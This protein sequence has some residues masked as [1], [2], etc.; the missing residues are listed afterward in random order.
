MITAFLRALGQLGD[1]AIL[2][3]I[4]WT[5]LLASAVLA[6]TWLGAAAIL[7]H[8]A[9]LDIGWLDAALDVL[10]GLAAA[11]L[12]L[13]LFPVL[14]A[15]LLPLFLDAVAA[16]V[17]RRHYPQLPPAPGLGLLASLG[18]SLRFLLVAL[19]LNAALLVLLFF[20]PVWA[21]AFYLVNGLLIGR[22]YFEQ[23][24]LR[25]LSQPAARAL[26]RAHAAEVFVAGLL[27]TVLFTVPLANLLAPVLGTAAMVHLLQGWRA[28]VPGSGQRGAP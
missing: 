16:A 25:R 1:T 13:L 14:F 23:V 7:A 24:A 3:C 22:E 18:A 28:A 17:E 15:A 4:G 20:P 11:V 9:V 26:R 19:L 27:L 10:G 12:A 5:A 21:V 6:A 2:R 8:T